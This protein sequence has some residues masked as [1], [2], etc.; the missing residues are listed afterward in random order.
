VVDTLIYT[1]GSWIDVTDRVEVKEIPYVR[2]TNLLANS[3]IIF[4]ERPENHFD[5]ADRPGSLLNSIWS[6][7]DGF[8]NNWAPHQSRLIMLKGTR[9]VG[10]FWE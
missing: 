8:N 4:T 6:G 9:D 5:S 2:V 3:R 10:A 7:A 1:N